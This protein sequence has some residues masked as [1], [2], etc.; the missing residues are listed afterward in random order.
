MDFIRNGAAILNER[1]RA[2]LAD[3]SLP[4][5]LTVTGNYEIEDTV[6]LPSDFTLILEDCHLRMAPGTFCNLLR[7]AG[8]TDARA[9]CPDREI[10]ILGR[11]R[12]ILDGGEYN[13]LSERNSEKEGMPHISVNNLILLSNV[14]GFRLEGLHLR[15]QRWWAINLL[16]CRH[17]LLRDIDFLADDRRAEPDGTLVPGLTHRDNGYAACHIHNADGIDLRCGCRDILIDHVT[18]FTQDDTVALTGLPGRLE[19]LFRPKES[20]GAALSDDIC[21]VTIRN[22]DCEAFC[23]NIRLLNQGGVRLYNILVDGMTDSSMGSAHM[24]RGICGVRIGDNHLYGSRHST[25]EET[26]NITVRNVYSRA[27][28]ALRLAGCIAR[29]RAENI[30]CFDGARARIENDAHLLDAEGI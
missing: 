6:L 19:S 1:I 29:L 11:G 24:D 4:R 20:G 13:G 14:D 15:R 21:N 7:N 27:D 2:I 12:A 10:R 28:T 23:A 22:V 25:F 26:F 18:G 3:P 16:W 17:G 5:T 8:A 30:C 9:D